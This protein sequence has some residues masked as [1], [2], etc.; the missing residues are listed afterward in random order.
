M[1]SAAKLI[2]GVSIFAMGAG[3]A[4]CDNGGSDNG[5]AS[6]AAGGP[7]TVPGA[8]SGNP[9]GGSGNPAAGNGQVT[10]GGSSGGASG[11]G[12]GT[13]GSGVILPDG[14]PLTPT[15]GWVDVASNI[16]GV[17]GAMYA[18][19]DDTTKLTL[20][21]VFMGPTGC[22]KGTAAKVVDPCTIP[23]RLLIASA[24]TGARPS[25]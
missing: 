5:G 25:A 2:L 8:G 20:T 14:I 16:L 9:S 3:F 15:D 13:A 12:T 18:Y 10:A 7:V 19:A 23:R 11:A 21:S 17:Q 4:A 6:N 1:S 24:P 22:M